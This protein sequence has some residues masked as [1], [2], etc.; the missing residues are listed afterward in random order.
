MVNILDQHL[1][2][3]ATGQGQHVAPKQS[4]KVIVSAAAHLA[5]ISPAQVAVAVK[6][7]RNIFGYIYGGCKT[8]QLGASHNT[9]TK[10]LYCLQPKI[11]SSLESQFIG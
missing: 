5:T 2:K 1:R 9:S 10:N 6:R 3:C 7:L 4:F 11:S 8:L